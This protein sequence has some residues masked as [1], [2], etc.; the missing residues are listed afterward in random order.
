MKT[1]NALRHVVYRTPTELVQTDLETILVQAHKE[2]RERAHAQ[3]LQ[4]HVLVLLQQLEEQALLDLE[5]LNKN[6]IQV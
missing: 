4:E 3:A 5:E 2:P 1:G 6:K